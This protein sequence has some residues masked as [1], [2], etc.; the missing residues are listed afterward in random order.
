MESCVP[1]YFLARSSDFLEFQL[2]DWQPHRDNRQQSNQ[3]LTVAAVAS[4]LTNKEFVLIF[5]SK[6]SLFSSMDTFRES[7]LCPGENVDF[8]ALFA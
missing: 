2:V 3:L 1:G 4:Y 7:K 8:R 6:Y 5:L